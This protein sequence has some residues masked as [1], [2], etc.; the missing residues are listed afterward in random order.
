MNATKPS[1]AVKMNVACQEK[2]PASSVPMGTP[3]TFANVKPPN[4][5]EMAMP[6]LCSGTDSLA[7]TI[8][9]EINTPVTMAV[10]IR[11]TSRTK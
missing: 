11:S 10:S 3:M 4:T 6:R 5:N 1:E 9:N 8:A 7:T 2:C